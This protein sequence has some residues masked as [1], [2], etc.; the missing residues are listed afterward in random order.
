[1]LE[2][3]VGARIDLHE[4]GIDCPQMLV[5]SLLFLCVYYLG[6]PVFVKHLVQQP[7]DGPCRVVCAD[8]G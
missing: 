3:V 8:R 1:M 6:R 5:C 7:R 4:K 2:F